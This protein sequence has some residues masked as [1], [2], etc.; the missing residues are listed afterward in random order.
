MARRRG[1]RGRR[2]V[3]RGPARGPARSWSSS[4]ASCREYRRRRC[5]AGDKWHGK[6]EGAG[7][8]R[9]EDATRHAVPDPSSQFV[10]RPSKCRKSVETNNSEEFF[11]RRRSPSWLRPRRGRGALGWRRRWRDGW[12]D[13]RA[14]RVVTSTLRPLRLQCTILSIATVRLPR[15]EPMRSGARRG[16]GHIHCQRSKVVVKGRKVRLGERLLGAGGGAALALGVVL[17]LLVRGLAGVSLGPA[18][19]HGAGKVRT[20]FGGG[21]GQSAWVR[22]G[23][24]KRWRKLGGSG[25][26]LTCYP[27]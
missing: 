13:S 2:R 1:R 17:C 4:R 23:G 18:R 6:R 20:R 14:G 7:H 22:R 11:W 16:D 10:N 8:Y 25:A 24:R 9:P 27:A 26:R 15:H 19:T 5:G 21:N 12:R 3:E